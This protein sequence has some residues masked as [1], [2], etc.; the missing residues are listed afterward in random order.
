MLELWCTA[1]DDAYN[2][3]RR[4]LKNIIILIKYQKHEVCLS[5][6]PFMKFPVIQW[7][8]VIGKVGPQNAGWPG[9]YYKIAV[10]GPQ[11]L[12]NTIILKYD[13]IECPQGL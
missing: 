4:S 7:V 9:K 8:S 1:K 2:S 3:K 13:L 5:I 12:L 11:R 6:W 10:N